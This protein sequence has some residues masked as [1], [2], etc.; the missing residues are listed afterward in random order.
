MV[1]Q[2]GFFQHIYHIG[3]A[4][5]LHS[6]DKS[7]KDP[8]VIDLNVPRHA[9]YLHRAWKKHQ[10]AV[11][12]V[13]IDLAIRKGLKFHQ[14][15]SN[16]IILQETLPAY[17]IPKVVRMKTGE[18][19]FFFEK[20]YMPPR[21]PP[22]ISLKHEWKRQM[23][24]ERAQRSQVG[25]LSRSFQSN[26]PTLN[27][28]R[29]RSG[30]PDSTQD[31]RNTSRSQE[32]DVNSSCEE[33][34]SSERTV[35]P[36]ETNVN[37]TRS[38]EDRKDFNVEQTRERTGRPVNTHDVTDVIDSSQTR[39]AHESETFNVEDKILRKKTERSVADHDVS[40]DSMM[41]NEADMDFRIP[42][43][44][45]SVVK[46]AQ[47]TSVRELIQKIENHPDR[48]ALQQDLRQNQSF[49]PESKKLIQD[50]GNIEVCELLETEP[51]RSA[52][53]VYRTGISVY[54]TAR[55]GISCIKKEGPIKNSSIIR[56]TFFQ[57]LSMSSRREDLMDID[58]VKSR[59]TKN[60]TQLTN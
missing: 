7:H 45:H 48:H 25:Q 59:E 3:C 24:S 35:R 5:N 8:K 2:S 43:P 47:S 20:V 36:D 40:H 27:P 14:T 23:G 38:S 22:K 60:I 53:C 19:F 21:P 6:M 52:Q 1:I 17:C 26:Q 41:V 37:P 51:K 42:G 11:Y 44:P 28:I 16:A 30:R 50:V 13:D 31:G 57:S 12:W 10:D 4:F 29:E 56:W 32:I 54:S 55:A 18:V 15:R 49:S 9:R 34:S 39:S 46:H 58:M 33:P